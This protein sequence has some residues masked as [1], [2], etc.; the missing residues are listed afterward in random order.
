MEI[1]KTITRGHTVIRIVRDDLTDSNAD[2]I[3]NAANSYLQHGGGVAGAISRKGGHIIQEESN[4]IGY[5]PAG[6]CA[7]TSGGSLRARYVIHAVGPRWGE[8]DE[9]TKLRNAVVNTLSLASE[10]GFK[11]LSLPAISAGIF[12]FPKKRCAEIM[13]GETAEFVLNHE[14]SL[15][16]ITFCLMD[17]DIIRFFEEELEKLEKGN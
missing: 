12:G 9:E 10:R 15:Q 7:I 11:T 14:T 16:E 13:V 3:V 2:A 5:V 6:Q 8:G 17:R 1:L 4:L